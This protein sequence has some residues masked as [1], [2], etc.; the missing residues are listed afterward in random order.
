MHIEPG[1]VNGAKILLGYATAAGATGATLAYAAGALAE[2]GPASLAARAGA[3][4]AL[5]FAFFEILPHHPVGVSEVHL[6]LGS[7]LFLLLGLVPA[8]LGL[9]LGLLLQGLLFAPA[10]L[11]Q[12]AMNVTTLL[13]PLLAVAALAR[14]IVPPA[15]PH[16]EL[17]PVQVL[18]LSAT[19]QGGVVAWVAFWAFW[20]QGLGAAPG[21][22]AFAAA[23]LGVIAVETVAA[24]GL[25]FGAKKARTLARWGLVS[26]RLHTPA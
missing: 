3:A 19:Y 12:Y 11:P 7:T 16:V 21:V 23:Y 17:R 8:A 13:V 22:V 2:R 10:D 1:V 25:L 9:A 4:M 5:T 15:T 26:P 18:A 20:G 24:L 6:I 14:R